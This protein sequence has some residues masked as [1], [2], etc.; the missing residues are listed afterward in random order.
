MSAWIGLLGA[1]AGAAIA[2][3]GQQLGYR[4]EAR[5]QLQA[6]ILEQ[7]S[8]LVALSQDFRNRVWEERRGIP[9]NP[10][11]DWDFV[12]YRLAEAKLQLLA[13]T[14]RLSHAIVDLRESGVELARQWRLRHEWD[15]D[16]AAAWESNGAAI[17]EFLAAGRQALKLE[18]ARR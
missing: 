4:A 17:E 1:V 7:C 11:K 16:A 14:A 18:A 8:Q 6:Q 3:V 15:P 9:A 5:D 10:V 13:P 2:I 12:G